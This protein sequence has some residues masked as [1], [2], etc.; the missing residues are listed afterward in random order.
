[1]FKI[2]TYL[3]RPHKELVTKFPDM[4]MHKVI[5]LYPDD[6]YINI[7][8]SSQMEN[9]KHNIEEDYNEYCV[10]ISFNELNVVSFDFCGV[11]LWYSYIHLMNDYVQHGSAVE[12]YGIDPIEFVLETLDSNLVQF[13]IRYTNDNTLIAQANLPKKEFLSAL[14]DG[15]KAYY[16]L[17][18]KYQPNYARQY[19]RIAGLINNIESAVI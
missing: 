18:L 4:H 1:M 3:L 9:F 14:L 13:S 7:Q 11:E 17:M 16:A 15:A 10:T 19:K 6:C 5:A 12:P 8:D 2:N